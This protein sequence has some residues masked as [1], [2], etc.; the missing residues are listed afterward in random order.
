MMLLGILISTS[1]KKVISENTSGIFV[2]GLKDARGKAENPFENLTL[3]KGVDFKMKDYRVTYTG[4]SLGGPLDARDYFRLR[5]TRGF[6]ED[7]TLYPD[8][9]K[10]QEEGIIANPDAKHYLTHDV[11]VYLTSLPSR[12]RV[13]DTSTYR[14]HS[15]KPG[16]TLF[17]SSGLMI[18]NGILR[19]ARA[20]VSALPSDSVFTAD[21]TVHTKDS[22]LYKAR[23]TLV[24][25]S[26]RLH[27]Y[28][29]TVMAAGLMLR[30][31]GAGPQGITLG[32]RESNAIQD[33]VTVKAYVF[34]YINLLKLGTVVMV[35]GLG[36]SVVRRARLG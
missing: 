13:E 8:A 20:G 3:L 11:F 14:D 26:D 5:F 24:V 15:L 27:Y 16:D 32:V 9:G 21:I 18:F 31:S 30:F 12:S 7:F 28:P 34:P 25:S 1:E 4:D 19:S 23:P 6:A 17:Y 33:F 10:G 29:D 36:M 22:A 35:V 2:P